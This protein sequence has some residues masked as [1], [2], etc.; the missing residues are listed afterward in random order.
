MIRQVVYSLLMPAMRLCYVFKIPMKDVIDLVQMAYYHETRKNG[1]KMKE[2]STLLDVSMRKV[3]QLSKRLKRNFLEAEQQHELPRRIEFVLW[4]GPQSE[5][6]LCQAL[7]DVPPSA[8]RGGLEKL[9]AEGRVRRNQGR[10]V[11]YET[12]RS[13]YRL[14]TDQIQA[15]V[16]GLNNLLNSMANAVYGRFFKKE[17]NSF[18]RTLSLRVRRQDLVRLREFYD[19]VI[20]ETLRALDEAARLDDE[21]QAID[22]SILWAPYE[23]I[24]QILHQE[25]AAS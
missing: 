17:I 10:T 3:A 20:W 1:L 23:Y 6:R 16:D 7:D 12:I 19:E 24:Q 11:T 18:A 15:R 2:A 8:V 25:E 13:E 9:I 4:A 21:A 5:R 14:V 22:V